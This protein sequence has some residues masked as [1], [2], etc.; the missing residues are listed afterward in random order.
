MSMIEKLIRYVALQNA[1]KICK[2]K[3]VIED[4]ALSLL[5]VLKNCNIY[6]STNEEVLQLECSIF[7]YKH[8]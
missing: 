4:N 1:E 2:I 8:K 3:K 6:Y 7:V 5:V